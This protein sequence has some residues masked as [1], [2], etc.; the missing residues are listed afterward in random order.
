MAQ[1]GLFHV[2][3]LA[4]RQELQLAPHQIL[5]LEI[6]TVPLLDLQGK[7]NQELEVNP[8]LERLGNDSERLAGDPMESINAN[9]S[10]DSDVAA[11][12]AEKDD[13]LANLMQLDEAWHEYLPPSH[14]RSYSSSDDE[15]RRKYF[16]DS[17]TNE[18]TLEGDLLEQLRTSYAGR[19]KAWQA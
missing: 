5:S 17:L 18:L 12:A 13:Y 11:N 4:L 9:V 2:Q 19:R 3:E 1:Q 10:K 6:L 16:F 7:I 15:E 8:T 14:A